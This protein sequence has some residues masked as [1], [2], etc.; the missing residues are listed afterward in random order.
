MFGFLIVN[1]PK[2]VS[3]ICLRELCLLLLCEEFTLILIITMPERCIVSPPPQKKIHSRW[4]HRNPPSLELGDE[5]EQA[6]FKRHEGKWGA[7]LRPDW[8]PL[9]PP[10]KVKK[11]RPRR[12][13]LWTRTQ[14]AIELRG[15]KSDRWRSAERRRNSPLISGGPA[16]TGNKGTPS[17]SFTITSLTPKFNPNPINSPNVHFNSAILSSSTKERTSEF[18]LI[19]IN[20]LVYRLRL[21][22][23]ING[24]ILNYS[25]RTVHSHLTMSPWWIITIDKSQLKVKGKEDLG[26]ALFRFSSWRVTRHWSRW[27]AATRCIDK[28]PILWVCL[29]PQPT[30]T[31]LR[32]T[33]PVT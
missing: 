25:K 10:W 9:K 24:V 27:M 28:I 11:P 13:L 7:R 18:T 29:S 12:W 6:L 31:L 17:I 3:L 30:E 8:W 2:S 20:S 26:W 14:V 4:R 19:C 32:N 23:V 22:S 21:I 15:T 16:A 5:E 33:W 1:E